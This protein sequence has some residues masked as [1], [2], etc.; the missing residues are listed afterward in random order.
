[1]APEGGS[2]RARASGETPRASR[3]N[4]SQGRIKMK[5]F[6]SWQSDTPG[7]IGR[8]F[9]RDALKEAINALKEPSDIDEPQEREIKNSLHLDQDR[10]GILGS[11]DLA[12]TIFKKIRETTVFIADVTPVAETPEKEVEGE[13]VKKKT[14]NPNVAIELGY[15]IGSL[16]D[17]AVLMVMNAHYGKRIDLPFDLQHKAGPIFFSLPPDADAIK[18]KSEAA[19]LKNQLI[20]AL[21]PYLK[22]APAPSKV[23]QKETFEERAVRQKKEILWEKERKEFLASE[24]GVQSA[25]KEVSSLFEIITKKSEDSGFDVKPGKR[26]GNALPLFCDNVSMTIDWHYHYANSL[27]EANLEVILW[28]GPPPIPGAMRF[29]DPVKLVLKKYTF[30]RSWEKNIGWRHGVGNSP[31][32]TTEMLAEEC[33]QFLFDKAHEISISR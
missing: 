24:A 9:I 31:L 19:N 29:E 8:F 16:S 23:T 5:I 18:I 4:S 10:Q 27:E 30:D 12:A 13:K 21:S 20:D 3:A 7:K 6:W 32:L 22:T 25:L 17:N 14:M 2:R 28:K 33:L 1:M 26:F 15:A 11:P